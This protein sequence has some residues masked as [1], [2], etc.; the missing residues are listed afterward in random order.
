MRAL[1][2]LPP[3][4]QS[5]RGGFPVKGLRRDGLSTVLRLNMTEDA[6]QNNGSDP[7][8]VYPGGACWKL[9]KQRKGRESCTQY[10]MPS[11]Q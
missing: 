9:S 1:D 5:C 3:K 4:G 2:A 11:A 7:F 6:M 8:F 10:I